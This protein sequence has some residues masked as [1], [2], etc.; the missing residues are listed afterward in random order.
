MTP[1]M[2]LA[3][4]AS[5]QYKA[6]IYFDDAVSSVSLPKPLIELVKLRASQINCCAYCVNMHTN[7]AK[8]GGETDKRLHGLVVWH[9]APYYTDAERAALAFTEAVTLIHQDRV[10]DEVWELAGK[11][12][13]ETELAELI[14]A[15]TTI[16]A[17]NRI[18]V[19]TRMT[20]GS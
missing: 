13:N 20:P 4:L 2:D 11:H 12:F 14:M 3:K 6:M 7:D 17:W 18:C 16:N 9:E 15:I 19:A 8:A 1:R 5:K 10:S